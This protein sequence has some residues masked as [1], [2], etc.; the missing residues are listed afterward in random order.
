MHF[1]APSGKTLNFSD[2]TQ[3]AYCIEPDKASELTGSATVKSTSQSAAWKQLTT[4]QQN[5]VN[6]ILAWGFGG[7]EAAK[8]EKVHYYYATQL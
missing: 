4:A 8:K 7:F 5:A 1:F 3:R 2:Y 6:L